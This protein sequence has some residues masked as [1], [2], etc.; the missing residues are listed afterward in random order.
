MEMK[1][2][3]HPMATRRRMRSSTT[4]RMRGFSEKEALGECTDRLEG[5]GGGWRQKEATIGSLFFVHPPA[6]VFSH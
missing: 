6:V 2:G 1:L 5:S 4:Q 3:G